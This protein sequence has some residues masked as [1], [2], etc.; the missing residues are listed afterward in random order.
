MS[1]DIAHSYDDRDVK[2]PRTHD[3]GYGKSGSRT[4][5][6]KP[7]SAELAGDGCRIA[8]P[9]RRGE[10]QESVALGTFVLSVDAAFG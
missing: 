2:L 6:T 7:S 4:P 10:A 3:R 9:A 1:S 5:Q 8:C